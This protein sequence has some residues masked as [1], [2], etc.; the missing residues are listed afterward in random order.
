M[1]FNVAL[2][3]SLLLSPVVLAV[4][5]GLGTRIGRRGESYQSQVNS[6]LEAPAGTSDVVYSNNWA[7]AVW[8]EGNV[9]NVFL[10]CDRT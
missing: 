5:S 8:V 1:L 10:I 4:P 9:G 3:S 2:F 7:G 6:R